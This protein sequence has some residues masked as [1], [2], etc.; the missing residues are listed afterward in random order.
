M[1]SLETYA[2]LGLGMLVFAVFMYALAS[3]AWRML[4]ADGRLRLE[5]MLG[6]RG[7]QLAAAGEHSPYDAAVAARR[8]AGCAGKTACDAWLVSGRRDGFETFC[9]NADFIGRCTP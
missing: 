2:V 3:T 9:P 7:V 8:C 6:R 1:N 5:Q 4:H